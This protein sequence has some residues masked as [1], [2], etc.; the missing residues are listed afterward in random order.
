MGSA[1]RRPIVAANWKLHKTVGEAVAFAGGLLPRLAGV[2]GIEVVLCPPFTALSGLQAVLRGGDVG[3]GAQDV[4]W[5]ASGAFT[6]EVAPAMLV[7][8]GCRYVIVG[9]SERRQ[10][11]GETDQSVNRKLHAALRA[12]LSPILC[13]GER[14]EERE[15]GQTHRVIETQLTG[16]FAGCGPAEVV[17]CVIAY[18]P[19]WAI[20]TGR[21]ATPDQAQEAHALLRRRVTERYGPS[22]GASIRI[23]YGGSV[24][25]ANAT[26]LLQAPDVD[27]AL[28]GGASLELASFLAIV[29]AAAHAAHAA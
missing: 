23:Q 20:G 10:A 21:H 6:G 11:F 26:A 5:E 25:A 14:L 24:N 16:A 27:G 4:Y 13:V 22:V 18:E 15:A 28:V 8:V 3:L 19:V 12:G 1:G 9:H 17:R 29:E 7:D 2:A